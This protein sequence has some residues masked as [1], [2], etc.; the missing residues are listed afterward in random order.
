MKTL[1]LA[2]ALAASAAFAG[3]NGGAPMEFG[4][5]KDLITPPFTMFMGGYGSRYN[6]PPAGI[7]DD[8]YV[9]ALL[10]EDGRRRLLFVTHDLVGFTRE[11]GEELA[12]YAARRHGIPAHHVVASATHTH[13][14]PARECM[15]GQWETADYQEFLRDRARRC[16]DRACMATY[17]GVMAFGMA[18]GDWNMNRRALVN[19]VIQNAP[20]PACPVD[21]A[22]R[23][24]RV[25]GSDGG[26]S[27]MLLNYA[28]HPVTLGDTWRLS[29]EFPGRLCQ[30]L[31]AAEYGTTALF[32]QGAGANAR[33]RIAAASPTSWKN[34]SFDDVDR[35][36]TDMA[37]AVRSALRQD[38]LQRV[39]P[40]FS[41]V[42]F[43]IV[44]PLEVRTKE[45][46][47]ETLAQE[48]HPGQRIRLQ[49]LLDRYDLTGDTHR[50][51]AGI[52]R[53]SDS[54]YV[55][56]MSGEVWRSSWRSRTPSP[57]RRSS[58]S[59]MGIPP[60]TCRPTGCW[61]KGAMSP[62]GRCSASA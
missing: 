5:A 16:I 18:E 27:A 19:G 2:A 32:F 56:W 45:V 40:N 36:A 11:Y 15:P 38:R 31:E 51:R 24:L 46:V 55:A 52:V 8:L 58:S 21:R 17:E 6:K 28:C 30:L 39:A 23:F 47:R 13:A 42:Q 29:A 22:L 62:R 9:K 48:S 41:A 60:P 44:L 35:M 25:S 53:L 7:H 14:G 50:L 3:P 34:C 43:N 4:V 61:T 59:A 33:P 54:V 20:N 12:D 57:A 26:P 10:L 37:S 1:A 49:D